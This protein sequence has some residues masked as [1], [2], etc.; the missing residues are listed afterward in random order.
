MRLLFVHQNFPGQYLHLVRRLVADRSN[1]IVFLSAPN[2][3]TIRGVRKV[4]Y[5]LNRGRRDDIHPIARDLEF[6]GHRADRVAEAALKIKKLGFEPDIIIGHHGW[7]ELLNLCDVW[8][9]APLLGYFEFYYRA[10]GQDTNFDPEFPAV[11]GALPAVR[12]MNTIN[13]LALALNQHGQTPT[14]FQ[15]ETY[16]D[17]AR[18]QIGLQPEGADLDLC[19]PDPLARRTPLRIGDFEILP[20]DRLV[21][22]VA[23]NLEPYRGFH[24]MMRA[25]P[26]LLARPDVKI[27]MVGGDAVSYGPSLA[28]GTW[29]AHFERELAG[30]YDASRVLFPG[31]VPYESFLRLLQRSDVHVYL[32]Y[33]FVASWS[34][35]EALACGCAIV[36]ADVPSVAEFISPGC[37]GV[38]TPPLRSDALSD[39]ILTL[40]EDRKRNRELRAGARAFA[41]RHLDMATHLTSHIQRIH[42]II[43]KN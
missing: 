29:R 4:V 10:Q 11:E 15:R 8:P 43:Q 42:N 13:H 7:G 39:A 40:I 41:E 30:R 36:G 31:Q 19:R 18:E 3:N 38:L 21:T 12:A 25:L 37:N 14:R 28:G 9:K 23:R 32:T 17:W 26:A 22:Y 16:P 20:N 27:V 5:D 2:T 33:P 6:A 35:R 34:L 1:D 24:V